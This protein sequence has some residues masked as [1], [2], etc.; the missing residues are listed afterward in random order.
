MMLL[1]I[2][3]GR[4]DDVVTLRLGHGL[5]VSHPVHQSMQFMAD[6]VKELSEGEV[7]IAIYPNEQLGTERQTMELLQIGSLDITKVSSAV[8]ENFAP[9]FSVFSVPFLFENDEHM[10]A[11]Q[12][13]PIGQ[14]ILDSSIPYRIVSLCFYDAGN[15]SFYTT[16]RPIRT[17]EDLAGLSIRVQ[18]SASA[19]RM[20]NTL[21]GS[22]TPISWGELY[23]AL[24]QGVVQGAENNPPSFFLSRH[25]EVSKYYT[26]N[27]HTAQPD[28]MLMSGYTWENR[29]TEAQ[30]AI[31][32]QAA[33]ESVVYQRRLWKI[34]TENALNAVR[35]AGVE[36]IIPDRQPFMTA[37]EPIYDRIRQQNPDLYSLIIEIREVGDA[38]RD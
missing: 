36:V 15:R 10:Y 23:T 11:V 32:M 14:R 2:S 8:M 29:L 28:I 27:E 37:S 3:C 16:N 1:A 5:D 22:A 35:E 17:P 25:Y 18:E 4:Q 12:D 19:I 33:R 38:F 7:V 34:A 31:V 21:G 9:V 6:R 13:G 20:V 30:R 24:Q 26:L